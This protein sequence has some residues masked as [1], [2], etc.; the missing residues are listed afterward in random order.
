MARE[1][2]K[3]GVCGTDNWVDPYKI[4]SCKKCKSAIKGTKVKK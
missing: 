3:C 2:I 4:T 1:K